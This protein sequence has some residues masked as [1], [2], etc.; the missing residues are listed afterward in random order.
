MQNEKILRLPSNCPLQ[1]ETCTKC[2]ICVFISGTSVF[3][4]SLTTIR[5]IEHIQCDRCGEFF[6]TNC[7]PIDAHQIDEDTEEVI[8]TECQI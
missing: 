4:E 2:G 7:C 1:V 5:T 8:C 6:C 3:S